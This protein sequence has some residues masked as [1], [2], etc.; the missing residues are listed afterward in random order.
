MPD[1]SFFF[2]SIFFISGFKNKIKNPK[3][4]MSSTNMPGVYPEE[5]PV[6]SGS[7]LTSQVD[8]RKSI[9]PNLKW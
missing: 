6:A 1:T 9:F 8:E 3:Q 5:A 7:K 2:Y 4:F